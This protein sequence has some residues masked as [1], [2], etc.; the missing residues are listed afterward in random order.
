MIQA[1]PASRF[2]YAA[3]GDGWIVQ[4][5]LERGL[6]SAEAR[7]AQRIAAIA[8]SADDRY[9]AVAA[10]DPPALLVFDRALRLVRRLEATDAAGMQR[11]PVTAVLPADTRR[12]F[13]AMLP[14]IREVWEV[15]Y[16]ETAPDIPAG[17]TIH[18]FRFAEG[19]FVRG[20]LNPQRSRL[21]QPAHGGLLGPSGDELLFPAS[22][23]PALQVLYL[24][25][26][27]TIAA[28][29]FATAPRV[30][31]AAA[32]RDDRRSWIGIAL[33]I[34][35]VALLDA[36]T[37]RTERIIATGGPVGAVIAHPASERVWLMSEGSGPGADAMRPIARPAL[38]IGADWRPVPG[39]PIRW[40]RFAP[41][42]GTLY[43]AIDGRDG[44]LVAFDAHSLKERWRV[45]LP[46][47]RAPAAFSR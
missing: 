39:R 16:D 42:G 1:G 2:A 47:P 6:P 30:G 9:L 8:A 12:S 4:L 21:S 13:V 43:V 31:K 23:R 40:A 46:S 28:P 10:V 45:E 38:T 34:E 27:R 5:D 22:D 41:D 3:T 17:G 35:G 19:A 36:D 33:D 14:G 15:S 11:S 29:Q 7:V 20:F 25:G 44:L 24:D 26:R 37:W 18:D 32:W